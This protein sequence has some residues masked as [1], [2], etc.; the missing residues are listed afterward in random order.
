M[1]VVMGCRSNYR[2]DA[3]ANTIKS[4]IVS[5]KSLS[6]GSI[7]PLSIDLSNFDSVKTFV[8]LF[9]E[10]KLHADVLF[11]NAGYVPGPNVP[12]NDF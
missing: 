12:V 8:S 3:A 9:K 10:K 7:I 4:E 6:S 1:N 5:S 2:C 11:N